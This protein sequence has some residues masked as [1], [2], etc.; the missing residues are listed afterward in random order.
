LNKRPLV[1][2]SLLIFL[3]LGLNSQISI[4]KAEK[5]ASGQM[6]AQAQERK[7]ELVNISLSR[8]NPFLTLEEEELFKDLSRA[9]PIDY[10]NLSAIFYLPGAS[11]VIIN[12]YVL[13]V[14]DNIDGKKIIDIQPDR[15]TLKDHE[16]E[17]VV[18]LR[19]IGD[20]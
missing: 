15:V 9:T 10:L 3:D 11:K 6:L 19:K 14:N 13:E 7:V 16:R 17:Y 20:R 1:I 8:V 18:A 12:G 5:T 2:L 4:I